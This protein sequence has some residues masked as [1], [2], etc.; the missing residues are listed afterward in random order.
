MKKALLVASMMFVPRTPHRHFA[1]KAGRS[2]RTG[3]IASGA[4]NPT[5][6]GRDRG[7]QARDVASQ[8]TARGDPEV[9]LPCQTPHR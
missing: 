5:P 6:E 4:G 2:A 9:R 8:G 1:G 3:T 7:S